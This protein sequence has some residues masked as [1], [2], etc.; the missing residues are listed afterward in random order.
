M[1]EEKNVIKELQDELFYKPKHVS[2]IISE[3]ETKKADEFAEGYKYYMDNGKTERESVEFFVNK[4]KELG[5]TEFDRKKDYKPG[6]KIYFNNRGKSVILC[7]IGTRP[8]SDGVKISAAH[9]DSPRLDLKPNPLY[10][11]NEIAYFKTHYYGGI[12][13]YQWTTIPL[14]LHGVIVKANGES[15]NVCIGEDDND[16]QFVITDLLPHL[17]QNQMK[18]TM[19]EGVKGEN[20]NILIGSRPFS[21]DEGS[22]K[23]KL[24]IIKLLNEKYGIVEDDFLSAELE[25]VPAF[26]ARD[27]GLDRSLIGAYGHDDKVCAYPAAEAIFAVENP[28]YTLLTVLTD[29]EEIGSDGNTGLN[30]SYMKY[31]ISDLAKMGGEDPWRVLS[32]SECLSADVNAAFDPMFPEVSEPKNASFVNRGVVI[33]KYTGARGKSG[34]SDASAEYMGKIR[35]MLNENDVV[36]QIGELGKVDIGGGGTV[37]MYV[38]NL[39]IDVVDLGVPVLSMHAPFEVISKLDLYMAYRAFKAFFEQK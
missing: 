4:A 28:A 8:I 35:K 21:K 1:S 9:L 38:A 36:W 30:S 7:V 23:V 16:P 25:L 15:V 6:D 18:Q 3:E 37:A 14:S 17:A 2:E 5:F 27:I 10:E 39:D 12:K 13:K 19:S 32:A 29:K 22:E 24:N 11:D 31:F 20:L 33:T 26:K 34:S